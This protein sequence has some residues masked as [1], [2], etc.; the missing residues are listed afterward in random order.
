VHLK[1]AEAPHAA[2]T[3]R[4][5]PHVH[6]EAPFD[7]ADPRRAAKSVVPVARA[8]DSDNRNTSFVVVLM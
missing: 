6:S 4:C 1:R 2:V 8:F 5:S 3:P 7:L